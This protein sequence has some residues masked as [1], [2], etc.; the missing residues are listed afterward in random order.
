MVLL[1]VLGMSDATSYFCV[2]LQSEN[3]SR[4]REETCDVD[5]ECHSRGAEDH[6]NGEK[7][8][9]HTI[10]ERGVKYR[11]LYGGAH[12]DKNNGFRCDNSALLSHSIH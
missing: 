11:R 7:V 2:A 3:S 6:A 10:S 12:I 1:R 9:S 5:I 8:R 4:A